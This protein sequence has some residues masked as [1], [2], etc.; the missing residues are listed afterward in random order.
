MLYEIASHPEPPFVALVGLVQ[1]RITWHARVATDGDASNVWCQDRLGLWQP[2]SATLQRSDIG[3]RL[4]PALALLKARMRDGGLGRPQG[5][6]HI[7][8]EWRIG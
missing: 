8:P 4:W 5:I 2:I 6:G 3:K 1:L 7:A